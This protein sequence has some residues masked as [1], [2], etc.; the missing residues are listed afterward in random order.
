MRAL[1]DQQPDESPAARLLRRAVGERRDES[2]ELTFRLLGLLLDPDDMRTAYLA[3]VSTQR[4]LRAGAIEFADNL[5]PVHLKGLVMPVLDQG[6][7]GRWDGA[8]PDLAAALPDRKH[9]LR[10]LL[11]GRDAWLQACAVFNT[12][13]AD[14]PDLDRLVDRATRSPEP[15][16]RETAQLVTRR[17]AEIVRIAR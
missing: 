12:P 5:L 6:E 8:E 13:A 3:T 9:V 2:L 10:A 1:L 16:V 7:A 17:R 11:S 15:I 4:R 14:D